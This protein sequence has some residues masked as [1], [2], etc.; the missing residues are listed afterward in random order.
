MGASLRVSNTRNIAPTGFSV[1]TFWLAR[2]LTRLGLSEDS[3]MP[4]YTESSGLAHS[5]HVLLFVRPLS[6]QD[7][8]GSKGLGI[9]GLRGFSYKDSDE[10]RANPAEIHGGHLVFAT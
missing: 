7:G 9:K 10:D 5:I 2:R 8:Q 1:K 4:A 6:R 3:T